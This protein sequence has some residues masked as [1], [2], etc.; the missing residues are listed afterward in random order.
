MSWFY[1]ALLAPLLYAVVVLFD[2]SLLRFVYKSPYIGTIAAGFFGILPLV[3]V[4]FRAV[5]I[6]ANLALLALLAGF[7][8]ITYY[9]FYFKGLEVEAPSVVIALFN[10]APATI[11]V[12]AHFLVHEDLQGI[13]LL[14]FLIILLASTAIAVVDIKSFKFSD[15]LLPV[16]IAVICMD[17]ASIITKHV[18]EHAQFFSAYMYFCM[19]M[20]LGGLAFL[21]LNFSE[22]KK[23]LASI[24]KV[25][26]KVLPFFIAAELCN[27]AAEFTINLAISRGPV[28]LVKAIEGVQPMFMLVIALLLYPIA[29]KFFREAEE[30]GVV[31]KFA[32]MAVA[33]VGLVL[34]GVTT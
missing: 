32:L 1:L 6:P 27:V 14:G 12:L 13:Q 17:A 4:L 22:N 20:G 21:L 3:A 16:L 2:D 29:P 8:T 18:Y 9:F 33:V 30:G 15:A 7:L 26:K 5:S 34:I 31:R 25:L 23:N 19:G 10:L 28:S 11:P 24:G